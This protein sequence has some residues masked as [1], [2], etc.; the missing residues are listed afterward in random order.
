MKKYVL[1]AILITVFFLAG[2]DEGPVPESNATPNQNT[3]AAENNSAPA[4]ATVANNPAQSPAAPIQ[5]GGP[6]IRYDF[7]CLNGECTKCPNGGYLTVT[8]NPD[9]TATLSHVGGCIAVGS[10]GCFTQAHDCG[11]DLSGT[12]ENGTYHFTSCNGGKLTGAGKGSYDD[13]ESS[14][15]VTCEDSGEPISTLDWENLFRLK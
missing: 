5:Y 3:S 7:I 4:S 8:L 9:K 1:L 10:K 11:I 6:A 13:K 15:S 2:C 12:Y 14:G